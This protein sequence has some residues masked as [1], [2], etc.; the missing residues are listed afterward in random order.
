MQFSNALIAAAATY[1]AVGVNAHIKL[2]TPPPYGVESLNNGPLAADGSD[3][4]CK[5]RPDVYGP[6][7]STATMPIGAQQTLA[8]IGSAVHGGG[9]CQISLTSDEKPTKDSKFKVIHSIMGGCPV[10]APG[11]LG[12]DANLPLPTNFTY[13]IPAGFA[14]GKYT[15]ACKYHLIHIFSALL[16]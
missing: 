10:N 11:N 7:K 13:A 3:F 1:F 5:Q 8:F 2:G 16:K 6:A 15:L 14:P 4:P 12:D 9:S